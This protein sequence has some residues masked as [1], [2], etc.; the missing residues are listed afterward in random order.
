MFVDRLLLTR[1]N[2]PKSVHF[3]PYYSIEYILLHTISH[4]IDL[5]ALLLIDKIKK[6]CSGGQ[7]FSI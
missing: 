1:A 3:L 6:F 7:S 4:S 2:K 5:L